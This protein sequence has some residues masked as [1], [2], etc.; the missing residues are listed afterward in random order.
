MDIEE[1]TI[2][3][4]ERQRFEE[5][6]GILRSEIIELDS[7]ERN[8]IKE[9]EIFVKILQKAPQYFKNASYVQ[10]RSIIDLTIMNI[11]VLSKKAIE[12]TLIP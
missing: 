11:T 12:I 9:F 3:E 10:K 6:I 4:K 8:T 7:I 2:Y 5:E 1:K